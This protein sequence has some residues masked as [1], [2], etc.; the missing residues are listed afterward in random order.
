MDG[1]E[2]AHMRH[3]E[4]AVAAGGRPLFAQAWMPDGKPRGV[5]ALVHGFGEHSGRY[6][7]VAERFAKAGYVFAGLDLPGHGRT[8]G[9]QGNTSYAGI[10]AAVGAHIGEIRRRNPG[11]PVILYG[12]SL[13]GAIVLRF[14]WETRPSLAGVLS[15]SPCI[16][17]MARV[18]AW[19]AAMAR[20][21]STIA[22]SLI[23][24]NPLTLSDLSR[25]ARVG[26]A[27]GKDPLYH[28]KAS[29]VLGADILQSRAW[30]QDM[31]GAFPLPLLLMQGTADRIVD[32][33][34]TI[35][36]AGRLTGNVTL[37]TWDGFYHELHNEPEK[38]RVFDYMIAWADAHLGA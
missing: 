34:E 37:K 2:E 35:A 21:L 33:R 32:A 26:E 16:G 23:M 22:P 4:Y 19:K 14:A 20:I 27:A 38:E 18:P 6:A 24:A 15:S 29:T 11:L 9:R 17:L 8:E 1:A 25:D 36:L 3:E 31:K 28:N 7:H 5:V 13:G 30:F 10:L 12:H